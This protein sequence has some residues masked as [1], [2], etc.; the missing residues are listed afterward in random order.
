MMSR[1]QLQ[2]SGFLISIDVT[3]V[4]EYISLVEGKGGKVIVPK[5]AVEGV[6]Y[7]AMCLDPEGNIFFL[8]MSDES[9][10]A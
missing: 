3:D 1:K 4:D 9:V 5:M 10:K 7:L 2:Q 8:M 6:G